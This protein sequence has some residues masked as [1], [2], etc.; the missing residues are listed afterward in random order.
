MTPYNDI[1]YEDYANACFESKIEERYD[2]DGECMYYLNIDSRFDANNTGTYNDGKDYIGYYS[3]KRGKNGRHYPTI[4]CGIKNGI[5]I[6]QMI[7]KA[8]VERDATIMLSR[9][10]LSARESDPHFV[11]GYYCAE[12]MIEFNKKADGDYVFSYKV[13]ISILP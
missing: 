3:C 2:E 10:I 4:N 7:N 11:L 1:R 6:F 8:R 5:Y 13:I 9:Y 12:D